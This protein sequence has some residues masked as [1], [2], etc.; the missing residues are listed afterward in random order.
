[1][2]KAIALTP[3]ALAAPQI[4][5]M[6]A[7]PARGEVAKV[8]KA[9]EPKEEQVPLQVRLPRDQVRAIKVAAAEHELTISEFMLACFHAYMKAK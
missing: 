1:M 3:A 2:P 5:P 6:A 8:R 4:T 7:T 9:P